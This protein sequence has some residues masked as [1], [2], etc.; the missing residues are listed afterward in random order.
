MGI[1]FALIAG[2]TSSVYSYFMRRSI[3]ASG[4]CYIYNFVQFF[5]C[6]LITFILG[7]L[8]TGI[9]FIHLPLI[10]AAIILGVC[11]G[12]VVIMG[13]KALQRGPPGLVFAIIYSAAVVPALFFSLTLGKPFGFDFD[14]WSV[15]GTTFVVLGLAWAAFGETKVS[16][17]KGS[18]WIFFAI[19]A[20]FLQALFLTGMQWR[21]IHIEFPNAISVF[22]LN[23]S[24]HDSQMEWFLPIVC[25]VASLLQLVP[26]SLNRAK[27]IKTPEVIYG[28][29]GGTF[30]ALSLYFI[31]L[32]AVFAKGVE[33]LILF[34]LASVTVII[35]CGAW[36][37][38]LY[39]E[40]VKWAAYT[41]CLIGILLPQTGEILK[42][43]N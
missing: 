23:I 3:D 10:Y 15:I 1:L 26:I 40:K 28:V 37:Q 2:V 39:K 18:I 4:A 24:K 43:I 41:L 19:L 11:L 30:N 33:K 29:F 34:P 42:Q 12:S 21:A 16:S 13:A 20:F 5:I 17:N 25:F 9:W 35:L 8:R 32:S 38:L 27:K 14:I 31:M 36:G 7:P 6:A 22:L